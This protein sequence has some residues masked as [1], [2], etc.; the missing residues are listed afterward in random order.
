MLGVAVTAVMAVMAV[1]VVTAVMAVTAVTVVKAVKAVKAATSVMVALVV[2]AVVAA[3]TVMAV[4][5]ATAVTA[6]RAVKAAIAVV[7]TVV[8]FVMAG[9][10]VVPVTLMVV[11]AAREEQEGIGPAKILALKLSGEEAVWFA[12][13]PEFAEAIPEGIGPE[14]VAVVV[15]GFAVSLSSDVLAR[16]VE[17]DFLRNHRYLGRFQLLA[18]HDR[19]GVPPERPLYVSVVAEGFVG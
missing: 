14:I 16:S 12:L 17:I 1:T 13:R 3:M 15:V 9:I 11:L 5:S 6:V 7:A 2:V 19:Q 4:I 10:A 18:S 8:T